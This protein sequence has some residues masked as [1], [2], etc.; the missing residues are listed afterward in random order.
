MTAVIR[1]EKLTKS[2]GSHRGIV[3][4][5]LAVDQGEVFGF[6]GPTVPARRPRSASFS[7]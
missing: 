3:D 1:T 4:V 2:Y 7:I 6:L 5:D